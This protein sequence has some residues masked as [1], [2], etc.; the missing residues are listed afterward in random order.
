MVGIIGSQMMPTERH[1]AALVLHLDELSTLESA[2]EGTLNG[3]EAAIS[4]LRQPVPEKVGGESAYPVPQHD[5]F[6]LRLL[7]CINKL[8]ELNVRASALAERLNDSV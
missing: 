5:N 2:L 4:R 6:E 8:K 3:I 7:G 1:Q